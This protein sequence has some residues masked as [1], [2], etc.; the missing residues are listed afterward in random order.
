[1]KSIKLFFI[2]FLFSGAAVADTNALILVSNQDGTQWTQEISGL[3]PLA[4][5][6]DNLS[7]IAQYNNNFITVGDTGVSW[8]ASLGF[9][10]LDGV[11]WNSSTFQHMPS[12]ISGLAVNNQ[13]WVA[14][15]GDSSGNAQ[16]AISGDIDNWRFTSISYDQCAS[17]K[18][19]NGVQA[20][21]STFLAFISCHNYGPD[22]T[23]PTLLT[24]TNGLDWF[25]TQ[26]TLPP[27]MQDEKASFNNAYWDGKQWILFATK[28]DNTPLLYT[29]SDLKTLTPIALP[30]EINSLQSISTND[31]LWLMT[32][33]Y[34]NAG[35]NAAVILSSKDKGASWTLQ[36]TF[37]VAIMQFNKITRNDTTW[38]AVGSGGQI[39]NSFPVV[40]SSKDGTN[41]QQASLPW[42][43]IGASDNV[44]LNDIVWDGK[45]WIA[46]GSF[47]QNATGCLALNKI[48]HWVGPL[49]STETTDHIKVTDLSISVDPSKK[50]NSSFNINSS[51]QYDDDYTSGWMLGTFYG[52]CNE[53]DDGSIDFSMAM[54]SWSISGT[55]KSPADLQLALN[56]KLADNFSDQGHD[57]SG[58]VTPKD[59]RKKKR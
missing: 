23:L 44:A 20:N 26:T 24:S 10:S 43:A 32:G 9:Y 49:S 38:M 6:V 37:P 42:K 18:K 2:L 36:K 8:M 1:M 11:N 34:N 14:V 58:T 59:Q 25:R 47:D 35:N 3:Y 29:T 22:A 21:D 50:T 39:H 12:T 46:V 41:W 16:L 19:I 4:H 51:I 45:R 27:E 40:L 17:V 33:T 28:A 56:A 48:G 54:D 57:Y 7:R 31:D 53:H 52:T 55:R 15:G 5:N 13:G 30:A